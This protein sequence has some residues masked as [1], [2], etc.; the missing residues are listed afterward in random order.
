M[1]TKKPSQAQRRSQRLREYRS[2]YTL[3]R[4]KGLVK[5]LG[6][7]KNFKPSKYMKT[8]LNKIKPLLKGDYQFVKLEA[9][10]ARQYRTLK[11][12]RVPLVSNGVAAVLAPKKAKVKTNRQGLIQIIEKEFAEVLGQLKP[13][14][15]GTYERIVLPFKPSS[16]DVLRKW[17]DENPELDDDGRLKYDN[18]VFNYFIFGH[19]SHNSFQGLDGLI[20]YLEGGASGNDD[21]TDAEWFSEANFELF[22]SYRDWR[23]PR[24]T[25]EYQ[26]QKARERRQR[27][28]NALKPARLKRLRQQENINAQARPSYD[29]KKK[30]Q[31]EKRKNETPEQRAERLRK[32]AEWKAK[33]KKTK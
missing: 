24:D 20:Q 16:L 27:W 30:A 6:P 15:A 19:P 8:K 10:Q 21:H 29:R 26:R 7:G 1:A 33:Q 14:E 18:E 5:D 23:F 12:A 25:P 17:V 31:N 9:K 13:L 2:A 4:K 3:A 28:Y 11:N 22:R 32:L